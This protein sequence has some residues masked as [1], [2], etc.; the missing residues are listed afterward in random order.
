[1]LLALASACAC[2]EHVAGSEVRTIPA[3]LPDFAYAPRRVCF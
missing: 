3:Q 1:M 2:D